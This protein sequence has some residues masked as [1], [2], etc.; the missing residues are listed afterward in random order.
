MNTQKLLT[1]C[2]ELVSKIFKTIVEGGMRHQLP[3]N[4]RKYSGARAVIISAKQSQKFSRGHCHRTGI[5]VDEGE[6][7]GNHVWS[8]EVLLKRASSFSSS[9]V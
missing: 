4:I 1:A 6:E 2:L 7:I 8:E 3:K 5:N 9:I